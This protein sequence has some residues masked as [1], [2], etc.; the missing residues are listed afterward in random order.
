METLSKAQGMGLRAEW[1]SQALCAEITESEPTLANS[2]DDE[3]RVGSFVARRACRR[4]PVAT[5][6]LFDAI[7]DPTSNGWRGGYFFV[8]GTLNAEDNRR[9]QGE[10][11]IKARP[12]QRRRE[13]AEGSE[14]ELI[15]AEG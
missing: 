15:A 10:Y 2:W 5:Q 7:I 11:G 4:C 3:D 1:R 6:C 9:L 14:E 13:V 8:N 12:R